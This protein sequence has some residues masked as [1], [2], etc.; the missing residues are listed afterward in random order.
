M[1]RLLQKVRSHNLKELLREYLFI[2]RYSLRY[3][4]EVAWYLFVG[5]L[6][7]AV[8][9]GASI[10]SKHIIDAVTGFN[11]RGIAAALMFFVVMQ[12]AQ[13]LMGAI[14]SRISTRV[15][16]RVNQQIAAQVYDKLLATDWEAL[17]T[18]HSGDLLTR[19]VGDLS[20]VS[21][22]VLGWFPDFIT[23]FLQFA[24]TLSVILY[25]DATLALLALVSAPVTVLMSR[26][27]IKMMRHHNQKMRQLGS[28]MMTFHEESF[29][30]IQLIKSF[31]RIDVYSEK[32]RNLQRQ[33]RDASM[34]YNRF[35][36]HKNTI[37]SLIGAVVA[38]VC[39][40][41]SV[42]RLWSGH[43]TYGTMTLFLQLS[44]S[45]SATFSALAGLI[46][47]AVSAATSAGRIMAIMDLPEED[48]T[49]APKAEAFMQKHRHAALRVEATGLFYQYEDGRQVLT[50]SS[51]TAEPGQIVAFVGPS[52]EGKTTLLRLLL[53]IVR[54]KA[55]TLA[56]S[57][58]AD[59][60][61]VS[62]STRALFAYVP[63]NNT[64]FSG[65]VAENLRLIRPDATDEA[66]Y[67][68]LRLACAEEFIRPLPLGLNTPIRE[69]GGGFSEGQL[70]RLCIARA[71]LS[72]APILLLDEATSALDAATEQ[73]VL[74]NIMSAKKD[75]TCIITTHR[76]SVLE[77][78]HRIYQIQ[79]D[80][81]TP[82]K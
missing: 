77:I 28:Q 76:P 53:G 14:S 56:L 38:L 82:L 6:G 30:N 4:G 68:A 59:R 3:R 72:D 64:M 20:T 51:F 58:E 1:E 37:L 17:S 23:R 45:L 61:C 52:G 35:S 54:P 69:Q 31:D 41:W 25:Y 32:H 7:T 43:I 70:Q 34:D 78:S 36:I 40:L 81:I 75:R 18:Y 33:L 2:S 49:D 19:V 39:F 12:L 15:S 66:L 57:C 42:Q 65:T 63:Q 5:I 79:Q 44:G 67:D 47:G 9:L 60:I 29:Q 62:P 27:V 80:K 24:G 13:I 26:Y 50:D 10:L 8:S 55:G 46:P 21:S 11:T 71:L 74:E 16:I 22:S 73:A 48:R